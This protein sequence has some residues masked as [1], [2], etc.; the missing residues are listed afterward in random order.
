MQ[1][2]I[3]LSV[4]IL[5]LLISIFSHLWSPKH[6]RANWKQED[7]E[8]TL[9]TYR[10]HWKHVTILRKKWSQKGSTPGAVSWNVTQLP[11]W[12]YFGATFKGGKKQ[13]HSPKWHRFPKRLQ[14]G[15]I[16]GPL[17]LSVSDTLLCWS[18]P[19]LVRVDLYVGQRL[20]NAWSKGEDLNMTLI[21]SWYTYIH[22]GDQ[23]T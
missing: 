8:E 11:P 16:L 10:V 20:V 6:A 19:S 18:D 4:M 22:T 12:H 3:R 15:A 17:F 2:I 1:H 9:L 7:V 23:H 5:S 14:G 13:V 21:K